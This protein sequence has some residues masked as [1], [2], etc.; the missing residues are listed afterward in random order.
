MSDTLT[1]TTDLAAQLSGDL[2][3]DGFR[4]EETRWGYI[5]RTTQDSGNGMIVTQSLSLLAGAALLAAALGMW[6][7]PGMMFS[8]EAIIMRLFATIMFVSASALLLWYASRGTVSEIQ[9]DT[10]RGE[11]RE[12]IRNHTGKMSLLACYSFDAIGDVALVSAGDN[13]ASLVLRYSNS[14]DTVEVACGDELVLTS[15]RERINR[16][17][18]TGASHL[19]KRKAEIDA[20]KVAA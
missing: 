20:F 9:I 14:A 2:P 15:L 8:A 5:V 18:I 1:N 16:D 19:A 11:I 17:V 10:T 3:R 13:V 6:L 12:V 4:T 7:I